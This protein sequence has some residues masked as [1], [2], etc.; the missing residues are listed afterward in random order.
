MDGSRGSAILLIRAHAVS[1]KKSAFHNSQMPEKKEAAR[2]RPLGLSHTQGREG[3]W[4]R[5]RSNFAYSKHRCHVAAVALFA[6]MAGYN[7][8]RRARE[9]A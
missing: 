9:E 1:K 4:L 2:R 7:W 6:S 5:G 3:E 8:L